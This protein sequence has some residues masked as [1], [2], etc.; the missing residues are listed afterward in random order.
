[1]IV[2]ASSTEYVL[3]TWLRNEWYR[4]IKRIE[5]GEKRENSLIVAY[6]GFSP[7]EL[8]TVLSSKQCIDASRN[9]RRFYGDLDTCIKKIIDSYPEKSKNADRVPKSIPIVSEFHEHKYKTQLVKG[10]CIARGYTLYRCDCG[11]EYKSNFS[12]LTD[13]D[14]GDCKVIAATCTQNGKKEYVC[15]VCGE[16]K[17][18]ILPQIPH[19]FTSWTERIHPSCTVDGESFRQ[20]SSCG[21]VE[22][23]KID[24]L[25]HKFGQWQKNEQGIEVRH[26]LNCGYTETD[27]IAFL[28]AKERKKEI[29]NTFERM[30]A[31]AVENNVKGIIIAGDMFDT[32]R[33]TN[34]TGA[35]LEAADINGD[36]E[37]TIRDVRLLL[38]HR[39]RIEGYIL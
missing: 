12:D 30:V 1:M 10:T 25:G 37:V 17:T 33:I 31:Y 21:L 13:H 23:R 18:E 35:F 9:N 36:D 14:Y 6:D 4:Y 20:C 7:S 19:T 5:T 8:P 32:A 28:R 26:C 27:K 11:Y 34:L 24:K 38:Y 3:S 16:I 15:S 39:A 22:K 2:Y 29:L